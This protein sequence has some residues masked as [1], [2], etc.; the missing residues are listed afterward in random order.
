MAVAALSQKLSPWKTASCGFLLPF[1]R[2]GLSWPKEVF[3]S[4]HFACCACESAFAHCPLLS[5][6]H[7][8][9]KD[10]SMNE[11][12][13]ERFYTKISIKCLPQW[14]WRFPVVTLHTVLSRCQRLSNSKVWSLSGCCTPREDINGKLK[15]K[16]EQGNT[17]QS[18]IEHWK[19]LNWRLLEQIFRIP[20]NS[21]LA[22]RDKI[23]VNL[24][25]AVD[26]VPPATS[27]LQ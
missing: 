24:N 4:L 2:S 10:S 9:K 13:K 27:L 3:I 26:L 18:K 20:P 23:Q 14:N 16:T 21:L 25:F 1:N 6:P 17:E 15:K 22:P 8:S 5:N 7:P 11:L 12:I 19:S